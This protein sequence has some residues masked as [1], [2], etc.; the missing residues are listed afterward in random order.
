MEMQAVQLERR[1][2]SRGKEHQRRRWHGAMEQEAR[3]KRLRRRH[4]CTSRG[5][6][7]RVEKR[8]RTELRWLGGERR[9][10]RRRVAFKLKIGRLGFL[11][12]GLG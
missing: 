3:A 10:N 12:L 7:T 8:R 1:S 6:A 4:G 2:T 11:G 9:W 5:E